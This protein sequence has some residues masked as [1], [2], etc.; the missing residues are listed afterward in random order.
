MSRRNRF[1]S[2]FLLVL[3]V[4][5]TAVIYLE[6][7]QANPADVLQ[8]ENRFYEKDFESAGFG[9]NVMGEEYKYSKEVQILTEDSSAAIPVE[10]TGYFSQRQGW[11]RA[12]CY[13]I[14]FRT[15]GVDNVN[16][17]FDCMNDKFGQPL[18]SNSKDIYQVGLYW[19]GSP[20]TFLFTEGADVDTM[21]SIKLVRF[22]Q[23]SDFFG[24]YV[25]LKKTVVRLLPEGSQP[26]WS[27]D[28]NPKF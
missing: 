6:S 26:K 24:Y 14:E 21:T 8:L 20:R 7:I 18:E 22:M 25:L 11:R 9:L 13:M 12:I 2:I 19:E 1:V 28:V 5:T 17:L 15:N 4:P 16:R 10:V 23:P 27:T 3:L